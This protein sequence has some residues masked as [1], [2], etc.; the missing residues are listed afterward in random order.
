MTGSSADP[1]RVGSWEVLPELHRL[2]RGGD[3]IEVEPRVM[4]V[5]HELA[6][7]PGRVLTRHDLHRSVWSDVIVSDDALNRCIT[8]LRR[9]LGDDARSPRY[10]ETISKRGYRLIAQVTRQ[11]GREDD[12]AISPEV[13]EGEV[14]AHVVAT[15]PLGHRAE[16]FGATAERWP[17]TVRGVEASLEREGDRIRMRREDVLL[18]AELD[19]ARK[20]FR[21][22]TRIAAAGTPAMTALAAAVVTGML[23]YGRALQAGHVAGAALLAGVFGWL[24]GVPA[25]R[26]ALDRSRAVIDAFAGLVRR[27]S[28]HAS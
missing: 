10:I 3:V 28:S 26:R 15:T 6:R 17:E 4:A 8:R 12:A 27:R 9:I 5:L 13:V 18:L 24:A 25:R 2:R 16:V 21:L 23:L 11:A 19:E 22:T 1:Y 20:R 14:E 7:V